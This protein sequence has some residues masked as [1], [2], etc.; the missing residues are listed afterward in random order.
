MYSRSASPTLVAGPA[1]VNGTR[2]GR[3][4]RRVIVAL[5][6]GSGILTLAYSA[7]S[8]YIATQLVYAPQKPLYATPASLGLQ[9]RDVI[10]PSREDQVQLRGWFIPGILPGGRLTVQRTIIASH[11]S[12][13]TPPDQPA[14]LPNL[15]LPFPPHGFAILSI[16][17][18][19]N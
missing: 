14:H 9:F 16:G 8:I 18:S 4:V 12:R 15:P 1:A 7:L 17:L 11:G 2:T 3:L 10:F 13:A 19:G 5:L 6:I